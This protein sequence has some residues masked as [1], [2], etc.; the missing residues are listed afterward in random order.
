MAKL[1]PEL[2]F[3][4]EAH[5]HPYDS[6]EDAVKNKGWEFSDE[7]LLSMSETVWRLTG[8]K[9]PLWV[10]VAVAP[11][12]KVHSTEPEMLNK[13]GKTWRFDVGEFRFWLHAEVVPELQDGEARFAKE[14]YLDMVPR[15]FNW[16]GATVLDEE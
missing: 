8:N 4:G 10:V 1:C 15:L 2:S 14:A 5:T 12:Q 16:S 3:L 6:L 9:P 13:A 7:D 11:L